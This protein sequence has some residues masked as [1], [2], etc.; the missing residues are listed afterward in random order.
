MASISTKSSILLHIGLENCAGD[1]ESWHTENA[2]ISNPRPSGLLLAAFAWS[3]FISIYWT[4]SFE[5]RWTPVLPVW[6]VDQASWRLVPV[7]ILFEWSLMTELLLRHCRHQ[8]KNKAHTGFSSTCLMSAQHLGSHTSHWRTWS[9]RGTAVQNLRMQTVRSLY[10]SPCSQTQ[11][12]LRH[13]VLAED[14]GP[15]LC[16]A[17]RKTDPKE[18]WQRAAHHCCIS[19]APLGK[20]LSSLIIYLKKIHKRHHSSNK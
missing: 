15:Q 8:T 18:C 20:Y 13:S 7:E 16:Q 2:D 10:R 12:S 4:S 14:S 3:H 5:M 19:C 9:Y 6:N 17:H 1:G 11:A